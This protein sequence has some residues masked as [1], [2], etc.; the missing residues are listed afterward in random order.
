ARLGQKLGPGP[1]NAGPIPIISR[2]PSFAAPVTGRITP[3]FGL[4]AHFSRS[5]LRDQILRTFRLW[6]I[7]SGQLDERVRLEAAPPL[8]IDLFQLE[9]DPLLKREAKLG[10]CTKQAGAVGVAQPG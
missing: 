9:V 2:G 5:F 4:H 6:R 1:N 8:S 7:L 10:H 3:L